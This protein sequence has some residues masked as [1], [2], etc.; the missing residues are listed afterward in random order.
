L[1]ECH[2]QSG[3]YEA[4][5]T[6][7]FTSKI[8]DEIG[9][10][11]R[12]LSIEWVSA[13]EA[14]RFVQI[15]TSFVNGIKELG[16]LGYVE[17]IEKEELNFRLTV[18]KKA[19]EQE[20]LRWILGKTTEFTTEGNKYS[21]IFTNHEIKRIWEMIIKEELIIQS[22]LLLLKERPMTVK[23]MAGRIHISE[24]KVFMYLLSLIRK[25]LIDL[26]EIKG[27]SPVYTLTEAII[28]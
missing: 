20:K 7:E 11:R 18:A 9:I 8:L 5:N 19:V 2:Y 6:I 22:I 13:S 15:V 26:K 10:D 16:P 14:P 25:G 12:R 1:G 4:L 24:D 21:E 27:I 23:E 28:G 3:N 17:N